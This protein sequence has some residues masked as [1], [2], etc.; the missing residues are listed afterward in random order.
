MFLNDLSYI[1]NWW[2]W[3]LAIGAISF[4]VVWLVFRKFTDLG[5]GLSKTFGI[6]VISYLT[7]LPVIFKIAKFS[8][9]T[10]F[11]ALILFT[12]FNFIVLFKFG[13][14]IRLSVVGRLKYIVF[15]EIFYLSGL[16]LWS[17][18]RAHQPEIQG[19]EKF[20]DFGFINSILRSDY[21]PP[22]DMWFSGNAINYYWFGHYTTALLTKI[23]GAPSVITYNLM[24]AHILG[25]CLTSAFSISSTLIQSLGKNIKARTIFMTGILSA[26]L[27]NFAGNFHTPYYVLKNGPDNY[28][29]PDATRFI[30]YNPETNDKT[31][32]EFP[33]YSYVVS[34]LHGHLLNLPVV[35]I[36][37]A[38]LL[39]A[40]L[41]GRSGKEIAKPIVLLGFFL[42]IMFMTNTWDFGNYLFT[43][44]VVFTI[45]Y[46]KRVNYDLFALWKPAL[47]TFII[48]LTGIITAIPFI[49]NFKSIAEGVSLVHSRTPVWQ[50]LIL[51]GF[52]AV[53]LTTLIT[54][55]SKLGKKVKDADIF[56][57]SLLLASFALILIPEI[58]YVKDIYIASH[59]R[60]N[61][62]FKLTYQAFV[63]SYLVSGYI[64]SRFF[65][66]LGK[67]FVKLVASVF[68]AA[69]ILSLLSYPNFS[70]NS[71]YGKLS[72]YLSL[73][74]DNWLK[75]AYPDEYQ[76]YLWFTNNI[77]GQPVILEAPGDSYTDYN[78]ISSYTGLPTVSGWFVH[79]WLWRGDSSF[80]QARHTDVSVIYTSADINNT[81][82]LLEKY[83]IKYIIV[84]SFER[85]K[86]SNIFEAKFNNLGTPVFRSGNTTVYQII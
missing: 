37:L 72:Q 47:A 64:I 12:L 22:T 78:V 32:H 31:I 81:K 36:Y 79:E 7:F 48:L 5:Y 49:I 1:L 8:N 66:I 30:G 65:R 62:M 52:P 54:A 23:T 40:V 76:V 83:K 69:I 19:L 41:G 82:S 25:V 33:M 21:L 77:K 56:S 11:V 20:M 43:T 28:W 68:F 10:I 4:P 38:I 55:I 9:I 13:K 58:L 51:W 67:T 50:L 42:G 46:M 14:E 18:V 61:T 16:V 2:L 84:G 44:A 57:L 80:P 35:L 24:L 85:E 53:I 27:L 3:V 39:A 71:Y 34:D 60:A 26:L 70:V 6:V 45:V 75:L 29:Y 73:R 63:I 74:G 59:Y 86:F 17:Y 15:Q